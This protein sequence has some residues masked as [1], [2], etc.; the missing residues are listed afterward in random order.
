MSSV[1]SGM[2]LVMFTVFMPFVQSNGPFP[3]AASG[4]F[5]LECDDGQDVL[6]VAMSKTEN[7]LEVT[8]TGNRPT[9][10]WSFEIGSFIMEPDVEL[11]HIVD[12][13]SGYMIDE[14]QWGSMNDMYRISAGCIPNGS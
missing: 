14:I 6:V 12:V 9:G 13:P 4:K 11:R 3:N 10:V 5:R 1:I 7:Q 2:L 8:G